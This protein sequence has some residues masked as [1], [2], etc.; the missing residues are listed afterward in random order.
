MREPRIPAPTRQNFPLCRSY[1]LVH[2]DALRIGI[3]DDAATASDRTMWWALGAL[4][5]G[6]IEV[7]GV[8]PNAISPVQTWPA[9]FEDLLVRGVEKIQIVSG[10]EAVS[11]DTALRFTY[12]SATVASDIR[13][14]TLSAMPSRWRNSARAMVDPLRFLQ[15]RVTRAIARHGHF[16]DLSSATAFVMN[17]LTRAEHTLDVIG[18]RGCAV[19][20][21]VLDNRARAERVGTEVLSR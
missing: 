5:G 15:R 18:I 12:P 7:L 9:V 4:A 21:C 20:K 1:L 6:Q 11:L 8:W 19:P 10:T 2:F 16:S 13:F 17:A 3:E 14:E